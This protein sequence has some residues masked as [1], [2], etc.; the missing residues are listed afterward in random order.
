MCFSN[1]FDRRKL[2]CFDLLWNCCTTSRSKNLTIQS[3]IVTKFKPSFTYFTCLLTVIYLRLL[4]LSQCWN[5]RL[6]QLVIAALKSS[7]ESMANHRLKK[8]WHENLTDLFTSF[9]SCNYFTLEIQKVIFLHY[10]SYTSDYL[11]YLRRK[12]IPTVVPQL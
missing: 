3:K 2:Y 9:V 6:I 8:I 7:I 11:R 10:Y 5:S 1:E 12:Q 4:I